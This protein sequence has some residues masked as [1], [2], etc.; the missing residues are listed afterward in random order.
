M[1][2]CKL[3]AVVAILLA[4]A[5]CA[6][7]APKTVV[8]APAETAQI[9][10]P[11]PTPAPVQPLVPVQPI[12]P[13]PLASEGMASY[14]SPSHVCDV[15]AI[16]LLFVLRRGEILN[17]E[18]TMP[19]VLQIRAI[20]QSA[21]EN[22][23][24]SVALIADDAGDTAQSFQEYYAAKEVTEKGRDMGSVIEEG[25]SDVL[26][27]RTCYKNLKSFR[28]PYLF[29]GALLGCTLYVAYTKLFETN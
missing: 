16:E 6:T 29:A 28:N 8:D 4:V 15:L 1:N 5:G 24:S 26:V 7:D 25:I 18:Y 14:V 17:Y 19:L 22:N 27:T 10:Q 9:I 23:C 3:L 21:I 2:S 11:V 20:S 12:V 13:E